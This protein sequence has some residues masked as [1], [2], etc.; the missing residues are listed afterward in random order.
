MDLTGALGVSEDR[1]EEKESEVR[2][3]STTKKSTGAEGSGSPKRRSDPTDSDFE[4]SSDD[5]VTT[6]EAE[7]QFADNSSK[8]GTT[9][10]KSTDEDKARGNKRKLPKDTEAPANSNSNSNSGNPSKPITK[11]TR[12]ARGFEEEVEDTEDGAAKQVSAGNDSKWT[13]NKRLSTSTSG[14]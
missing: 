2:G 5:S 13:S 10:A 8:K 12:A 14:A 1:E 6:A 3:S 4:E 9:H 11:S 7:A